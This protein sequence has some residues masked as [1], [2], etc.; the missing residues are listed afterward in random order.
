MHP[1]E[2]GW[3]D[4]WSRAMHFLRV[5]LRVL[6]SDLSFRCGRQA[7]A[8]LYL[9]LVLLL[10]L[11]AFP[12]IFLG[13]ILPYFCVSFCSF[14]SFYWCVL[15][16]RFR[17]FRRYHS[18]LD[19]FYWKRQEHCTADIHFLIVPIIFLLRSI[20]VLQNIHSLPTAI[21]L[22]LVSSD[23]QIAVHDY[24]PETQNSAE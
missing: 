14:L 19:V 20:S 2:R 6:P 11:Q 16:F 24:L 1:H 18:P 3:P 8:S 21:I 23:M 13:A 9:N 22:A 12:R 4:M 15:Q 10:L 5:T 17:T 7:G